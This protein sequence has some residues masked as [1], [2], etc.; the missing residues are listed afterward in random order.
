[1]VTCLNNYTKKLQHKK[2]STH[3]VQL[4]ENKTSSRN[5]VNWFNKNIIVDTLRLSKLVKILHIEFEEAL[6][7]R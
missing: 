7:G 1:M 5:V 6:Q 2:L 3:L 4:I